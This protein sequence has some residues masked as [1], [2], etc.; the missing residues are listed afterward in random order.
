MGKLTAIAAASTFLV[1]TLTGCLTT[2]GGPFEVSVRQAGSA[3]RLRPK[4]VFLLYEYNLSRKWQC[5]ELLSP[6]G[7]RFVASYPVRVTVDWSLRQRIMAPVDSPCCVML[8]LADDHWP[9]LI[10]EGFYPKTGTLPEEQEPVFEVKDWTAAK[11]GKVRVVMFPK[12]QGFTEDASRVAS[13]GSWPGCVKA[14]SAWLGENPAR[15]PAE[16]RACV[17][18]E[19]LAVAREIEPD[20]AY[21]AEPILEALDEPASLDSERF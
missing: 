13:L 5:V 4:Y 18:A 20:S 14:L 16:D 17:R 3:Q 6:Q 19:L 7:D 8:I 15:L 10:G 9:V 12:A 2:H 11:G 1:L 21:L